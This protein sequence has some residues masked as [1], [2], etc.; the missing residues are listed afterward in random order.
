[1]SG[2]LTGVGTGPGAPDLMTLRARAAVA[3]A[4]VIAWLSADGRPSRARATA[5]D[6]IRDNATEIGIDMPMRTDPAAG[7]AAYDRGAARI[8]A[9][10]AAGRD[11]ACLCEGDPLLYG[12]FI[13]L[14]DRLQ[15]R[16]TVEIVPGLPSFVACAAIAR[17]PLG[18]RTQS[19]GI[20][21]ATLDDAALAARLAVL[22]CAAL[23]KTGR[24]APRIRALLARLGLL[25]GA[26]V[27]A[28]ASHDAQ[29]VRPM[30]GTGDS[31]PYFAT[32][33]VVR[34]TLP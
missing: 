3:A 29:S 13:H 18:R 33:L 24:H 1:M 8:A 10:L 22:D 14:M 16:F 32:V 5:A 11:V 15:D 26:I 7:A 12:S 25:D 21:P 31:L 2:R 20:V 23:I 34:E 30:A 27:V 4:P 9:E 28:E 19:F 17:L 6:A